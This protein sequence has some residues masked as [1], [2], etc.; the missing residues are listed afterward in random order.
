MR[1]LS[2]RYKPVELRGA[3]R[4]FNTVERDSCS[5]FNFRASN[6]MIVKF[7]KLHERREGLVGL[8]E[9][10]RAKIHPEA[11]PPLAHWP[12]NTDTEVKDRTRKYDM[13]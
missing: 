2:Q 6:Y 1:E 13:V 9:N 7:S 5:R 4:I 10:M 12:K 3:G 11:N 8:Q